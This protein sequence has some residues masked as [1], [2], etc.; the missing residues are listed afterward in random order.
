[1]VLTFLSLWWSLSLRNL[2][3][4]FLPIFYLPHALLSPHR[5]LSTCILNSLIFPLK[6]ISTFFLS[7]FQFRSF[8]FA[9]LEVHSSSFPFLPNLLLISSHRIFIL[10]VLFL[11]VSISIWFCF[12]V[13]KNSPSPTHYIFFSYDTNIFITIIL[14]SCLLKLTS[15]AALYL[16]LLTGF[17]LDCGSHFL[18]FFSCLI[19]F[20]IVSWTLWM[21]C[22][23][24][25]GCHDCP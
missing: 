12:T 7:R 3:L 23:R 16:F 25:S 5:T 8:L 4:I 1:M 11:S 19:N 17:S 20:F 18:C 24:V 2:W 22:Y 15:G 21:I 6:V 14:K 9:C 13:F 10:D